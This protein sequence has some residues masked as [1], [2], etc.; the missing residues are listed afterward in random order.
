MIIV[1]NVKNYGPDDVANGM[2][3]YIGRAMPG[4]KGSPLRNPFKLAKGESRESCLARYT[5][6][7]RSLPAE[8][9]ERRE[10]ARLVEIA[11][12]NDLVLLCWCAPEKCHGD[13]IKE[14]IE[15][16]LKRPPWTRP[17][18]SEI[19]ATDG[20][21]TSITIPATDGPVILSSV[22]E[23]PAESEEAYGN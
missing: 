20:P 1:A 21:M 22:W 17:Q 6:W 13:V 5:D 18:I 14:M 12:N 15:E 23:V 8:C 16:E 4:R 19:T 7:F 10:L 2:P 9:E 3:V 11:R